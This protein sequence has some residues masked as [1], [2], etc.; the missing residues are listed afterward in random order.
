MC[1]SILSGVWLRLL[2]IDSLSFVWVSGIFILGLVVAEGFLGYIL[3]FG[4]MSYWGYMVLLGFISIMGIFEWL[5]I[6]GLWCCCYV[7]V[8]RVFYQLG[9]FYSCHRLFSL[10]FLVSG[11]LI[12]VQ[13][14]FQSN[15]LVIYP[16]ISIS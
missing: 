7:V 10:L 15:V 16:F 2:I 6:E 11:S 4:Q 5:V 1:S 9:I 8:Y 13:L 12:H 3:N 14:N